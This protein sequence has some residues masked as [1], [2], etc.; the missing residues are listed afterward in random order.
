MQTEGPAKVR[1]ESSRVSSRFQPATRSAESNPSTVFARG[2]WVLGLSVA[3]LAVA[4]AA[5]LIARRASESGLALRISG[6]TAVLSTDTPGEPEFISLVYD[7][8]AETYLFT[9]LNP[10]R[11]KVIWR[12]KPFDEISDVDRIA[13]GDGKFFTVEGTK[14]YAYRAADGAE[15]WQA[16]LSDQLGYCDECLSATHS[17]VIVLTA[18]YN[19]QV[20]DAETGASAWSRWMDGYTKGFTLADGGLWVIDKVGGASR[21][22]FLD[23]ADGSVLNQITP[24]CRRS[25]GLVSSPLDSIS[26]FLL[27]PSPSVRSS[28]RSVYLLYGWHPGC[29]ECRDAA[30]GTLL[31]QTISEEGFSPS[32]DFAVLMTTETL[33][34]AYQDTL[35]SVGKSD[36][37]L[38]VVSTGGDY[39]L[40]PLALERGVLVL[41]TKRTRG[42]TQFG[43]RGVDPLRGET[44]WEYP[45]PGGN[46]A[47]PPEAVYRHVDQDASIWSWRMVDGRIRLFLFQAD[48]SRITFDA[49]DPQTGTVSDHAVLALPIDGDSYFGPE[50]LT[51][52][53]TT[54]WFV[55]DGTLLAVDVST[56]TLAHRFL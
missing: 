56:A 16:G 1:T 49:I 7:S 42:T 51:W 40:A 18:D 25:D 13:A 28:E 5:V 27:D 29:I 32:R 30:S 31:W 22:V 15:L 3:G 38:R 4:L 47:D 36:G 45:I 39:H 52:H 48:P 55:A 34:F 9:R 11:G 8:T 10:A 12:G 44:L 33:F 21:L 17:R 50:I 20:F 2:M 43:L 41:R 53:G 19:L 35:W 37:G 26:P 54:I 24:E 23:L 6:P 14:L 46:P